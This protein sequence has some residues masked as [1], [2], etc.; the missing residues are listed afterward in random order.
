MINPYYNPASARTSFS[1]VSPCAGT[2][3]CARTQLRSFRSARP[4]SIACR[5]MRMPS[6]KSVF[7]CWLWCVANLNYNV[8]R[9]C[10]K[11]YFYSWI[12][13]IQCPTRN[14][15]P[16]IGAPASAARDNTLLLRAFSAKSY[17]WILEIE[18][19]ILD[20]LF[21]WGLNRPD[22]MMSMFI[23]WILPILNLSKIRVC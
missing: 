18:C 21:G 7:C 12:F 14:I 22:Y 4:S 8:I 9:A 15:Q 6:L 17:P 23:S 13:N 3:F 11:R 20:I 16:K 10:S 19:W 2:A 5:L 1:R